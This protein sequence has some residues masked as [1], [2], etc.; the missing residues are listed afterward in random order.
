[1]PLTELQARILRTLAAGRNPESYLAGATVLHRTD[2]S[3]RFSQDLD[4]FHDVA[5]SVAQS[6]EAAASTLLEAEPASCTV[7]IR[8]RNLPSSSGIQL[9]HFHGD[10]RCMAA[11]RCSL[12]VLVLLLETSLW[13]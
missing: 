8:V 9:P 10:L 3:P 12:G 6:A 5:D 4:Y 13:S 11:D 1:M 2:D 7:A